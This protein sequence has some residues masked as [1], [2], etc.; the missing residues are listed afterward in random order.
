[1]LAYKRPLW[2][3]TLVV[4]LG[5]LLTFAAYSANY[6]YRGDKYVVYTNESVRGSVVDRETWEDLCIPRIASQDI[7][8]C[9]VKPPTVSSSLT[10]GII[11]GSIGLVVGH[12]VARKA[13]GE[14]EWLQRVINRDRE[15]E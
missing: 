11:L 15:P 13:E 1:M 5:G 4:A 9:E 3:W 2:V 6:E 8:D 7:L 12:L 14:I 10:V